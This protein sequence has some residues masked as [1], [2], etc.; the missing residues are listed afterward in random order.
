MEEGPGEHPARLGKW[1]RT[2]YR[3][4]GSAQKSGQSGPQ[5]RALLL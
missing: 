2:I 1:L 5:N 4:Q 3:G